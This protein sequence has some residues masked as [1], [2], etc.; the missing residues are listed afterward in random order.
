MP[1]SLNVFK[2]NYNRKAVKSSYFAIMWSMRLLG[3]QI[4]LQLTV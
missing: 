2:V 1:D 3:K 4:E